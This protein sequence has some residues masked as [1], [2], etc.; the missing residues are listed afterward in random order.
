MKIRYLT[1]ANISNNGS[2]LQAVAL[3]EHLRRMYPEHDIG[4]LSYTVPSALTREALKQIHLHYENPLFNF[5]RYRLF[6]EFV[7]DSLDWD[8]TVRS[9]LSYHRVAQVMNGMGCDMFVVG[10]DV[11]A[12]NSDAHRPGF[13]NPYWISETVKSRKVAFGVSAYNSNPRRFTRNAE[14]LRSILS[15]FEFVGAREEETYRLL[16]PYTP[17]GKLHRSYDAAF[18]YEYRPTNLREKLK[19]NRIDI[20]RPILLVLFPNSHP[21]LR[22]YIEKMRQRGFQVIGTGL[23]N[24]DVDVNLGAVLDPFEWAEMFKL[25]SISVSML[26]HGTIFAMMA[27]TPFVALDV[28]VGKEHSKKWQMLVEFGLSGLY[29]DLSGPEGGEAL[30]RKHDEVVGTWT[31]TY[32][33]LVREAVSIASCRNGELLGT[34]IG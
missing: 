20:G 34:I 17:P 2:L 24:R 27:G 19:M 23:Y 25:A 1:F 26:L 9:F 7:R 31:G 6:K 29:F 16:E 11:W 18:F 12:L 33:P 22:F 10:S 15:G 13:P 4:T 32:S 21:R 14:K 5:R 30:V 28:G 3:Q 8:Y